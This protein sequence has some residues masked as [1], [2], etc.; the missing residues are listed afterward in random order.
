MLR[1]EEAKEKS[2]ARLGLRDG[3]SAGSRE[4]V[5]KRLR[6]ELGGIIGRPRGACDPAAQ[7]ALLLA[8]ELRRAVAEV[9]LHDRHRL[10][11]DA[12]VVSLPSRIVVEVFDFEM[13]LDGRQGVWP[14][15]GERQ[16]EQ[17]RCEKAA[18]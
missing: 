18:R 1:V 4:S 8:G 2:R 11:F 7:L 15:S 17:G 12:V 3:E 5:I 16:N 14:H 6:S 13:R 9:L 10:D